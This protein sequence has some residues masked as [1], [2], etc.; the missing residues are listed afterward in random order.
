MAL[1]QMA[2]ALIHQTNDV[3]M[4]REQKAASDAE[5]KLPSNKFSI[6]LPVLLEYLQTADER[7]LPTLWHKWEN[8]KKCEEFQI[9]HCTLDAFARSPTALSTAVPVVSAK[10]VQDLL[11]FTFVGDGADNIK[12]RFHPFIVT[13]GNAEQ[14]L[15]NLEVA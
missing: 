3:H 6:T 2:M 4:T 11:N 7:D 5:P 8:G 13:N 14:C 9:L 12:T 10:L 15:A 1:S